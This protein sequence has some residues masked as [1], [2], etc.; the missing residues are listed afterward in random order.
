MADAKVIRKKLTFKGDTKKNVSKSITKKRPLNDE[1]LEAIEA[2]AE[3]QAEENEDDEIKILQGTGRLTS[4]G[5]T[6]QGHY[7]EF[8]NQ[9]SPGDAIIIV[10]PTS[11][12]EETKV[13]RMVLSNVSIG[14]SSSFSSD[15][16][17][18]TPF[19]YIKAPKDP[20]N[21][22]D[23]EQKAIERKHKVEENAFGT[24]ASKGG[25]KF[26]Y[27]V[28]KEGAYGGYKIVTESTQSTMSREEL[29]DMRKKKKSDRFCY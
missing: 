15:L 16:I 22:E 8:M 28:K 26:V 7:T 27:R 23:K 19:R 6:I 4:S 10:H 17:S 11:L 3:A 12:Q 25:E 14:I 9:L 1:K 5:T 29:L 18:T 21:N 20:V 13:V 24:Y 2:P